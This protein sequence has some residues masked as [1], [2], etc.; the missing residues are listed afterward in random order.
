VVFRQAV[1]DE[2]LI[3]EYP[4]GEKT[5]FAPLSREDL[6]EINKAKEKLGALYRERL[7]IPNLSELEVVRHFT[8]LTQMSFGVDTGPVPLG[9]CT[10]KYNPRLGWKLSSHPSV[11]SVHP[12]MI[13]AGLADG[14]LEIAYYVQETL[15]AITGMDECSLQPPAGA[16]GEFAG[17]LMIKAYLR[18]KGEQ[19]RDE[20]LVADSA[21]GTNPA[22]SAMGG[23]KVIRVPTN[24]EGLVDIDALRSVAGDRTAGFMLTNPNT[25]GLFESGIEEIASIVH[26][27]G[28]YLYYDG[29]N[30][31]GILGIARPGDMGFDIVHLNLHKTFSSPH[32]GGGPG[33]G[34]ICAKG[35]LKEYLPGYVI[36]RDSDG[37]LSLHRMPRSIGDMATYYASF[38]GVI[39]TYVFLL[40]HGEG[41]LRE[42]AINAVLNTNYL[43]SLLHGVRGLSLPYRSDVPRLHEVVFSARDLVKETG[44]GAG[45]IAKYLLDKGLHAPTIY[46]PLI[47]EEALMIEMTETESA[48]VVEEYAK[49]IKEAVDLAYRSPS[50][51]QS[52]PMNTSVKRL[53]AVR[54]N[55]PKTMAPSYKV[56]K[57]VKN[58]Q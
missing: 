53:D 39:Y 23:F 15:K 47:V 57:I 36:R 4:N 13:R 3:F 50:V 44:V 27:A 51:L 29:A 12:E 25:L 56:E 33:A 31:N 49:A 54:A 34:V 21:H 18:D 35:S 26:S 20:M 8:R 58:I 43:I 46:F 42:V 32:G 28:G 24:Q 30:L 1:W 41:G 48:E 2:P 9:S 10:M 11:T 37:K 22:S 45:D 7:N 38:T 6:E 17:V 5:G 16:S 40:G 14:L 19:S 55:H 52:S